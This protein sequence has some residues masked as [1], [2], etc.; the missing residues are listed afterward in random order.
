MSL[1][2]LLR[3]HTNRGLRW[4]PAS[5][6]NSSRILVCHQG[7]PAA[8]PHGLDQFLACG[9]AY[10]FLYVAALP[11]DSSTASNLREATDHLWKRNC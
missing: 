4:C 8:S 9:H 1:P 2:R 7:C 3:E 10:L 6:T 11:P 5:L